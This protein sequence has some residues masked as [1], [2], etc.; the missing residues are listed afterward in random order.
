[1]KGSD[2]FERSMADGDERRSAR[3]RGGNPVRFELFPLCIRENKFARRAATPSASPQRGGGRV[4]GFRCVR[5]RVR[6]CVRV[7]SSGAALA[8][9]D[10]RVRG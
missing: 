7:V 10:A 5:Q 1:M 9:A 6:Q 8:A 2:F 4:M 3:V